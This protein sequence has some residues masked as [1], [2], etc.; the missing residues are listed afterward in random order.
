V[1]KVQ[2]ISITLSTLRTLTTGELLPH[3]SEISSDGSDEKSLIIP[4]SSL[5]ITSN[6][7]RRLRQHLGQWTVR[8]FSQ[9]NRPVGLFAI[10]ADTVLRDVT[11]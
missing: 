6:G 4:A 2:P 10:F 3:P 5:S 1:V 9:V 11:R 7:M 8:A